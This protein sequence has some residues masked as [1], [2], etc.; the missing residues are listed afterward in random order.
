MESEVYDNNPIDLRNS[1]YPARNWSHFEEWTGVSC[2]T[3]LQEMCKLPYS[4]R[5]SFR[6]WIVNSVHSLH[7]TNRKSAERILYV[8]KHR[9]VWSSKGLWQ[10]CLTC[11]INLLNRIHCLK[12]FSYNIS[13][14][15]P[16]PVF[17]WVFV[18]R[19]TVTLFI[20]YYFSSFAVTRIRTCEL[21][22]SSDLWITSPDL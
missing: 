2:W 6:T 12:C 14:V 16:T 22:R 8:W 3:C 9:Y 10:W 5:T 11:N 4:T 1:K 15:E 18:V 13:G 7:N 21:F 17:R 19:T 20:C